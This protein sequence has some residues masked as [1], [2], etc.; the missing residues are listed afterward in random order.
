MLSM[1]V[2]ACFISSCTVTDSSKKQTAT[3]TINDMSKIYDGVAVEAK[4]STN[5]D[6]DITILYKENGNDNY[7]TVAPVNAGNYEIKITITETENYYSI[8]DEAAFTISKADPVVNVDYTIPTGLAILSGQKLSSIDLSAYNLSWTNEEIVVTEAG[9]YY[10]TFTPID[11]TNYN[12][13]TNIEINLSIVN[14]LV[15]IP[16]LSTSFD[17]DGTEKTISI[18]N[19]SNFNSEKMMIVEGDSSLSAT[20]AGTYSIV[21][22]LLDTTNY[23][24]SDGTTSN[25]IISWTISP[26]KVSEPIVTNTNFTYDGTEKAVTINYDSN[27][28]TQTGTTSA[29][30]ANTYTITFS[31]KDQT[32]NYVWE[33]DNS[34][35]NLSYTWKINKKQIENVTAANTSFVYN[36]EEQ[37]LNISNYN[38]EYMTQTGSISATNVG[39]YTVTYSLNNTNE[40]T[41]YAWTDGTIDDITISWEITPMT[42]SIPTITN[43]ALTYTGEELSPTLSYDSNYVGISS[44]STTKALQKGTYLITFVL[45]DK[46][47]IT[48]SDGTTNDISYTWTISNETI[49]IPTLSASF[50][51]DGTEKTISTANISNFNSEKMMIVEESSTLSATNA[52]TYNIIIAL[53]DTTNYAWNDGTTS[54][55]ALTWFINEVET[56]YD[57]SVTYTKG[58]DNCY[59]I[60]ENNTTGEYTITFGTI[61]AD[62]SYTLS[63]NLNGNIVIDVDETETYKFTLVLSDV[64]ITSAY[65][66][67]IFINT[68]SKVVINASEGTTNTIIDNREAIGSDSTQKSAAIYSAVDLNLSGSGTLNITS[69]NNNGVN[70]KD[71]LQVKN[72]TLNVTCVD[73]A[74]KGN[75]EV[76]IESG[77]ITLIATDGDGIKTSNN[78][79]SSK[80]NQKGN[81][82]ISGGNIT[83]YSGSDGID[84]AYDVIIS[85]DST[86]V[87][88]YTTS[89]YAGD[90]VSSIGSVVS[91]TYYILVNSS[92]TYTYSIRY[93]TTSGY[94]M[95]NADTTASKTSSGYN[96][97]PVDTVAGATSFEVYVYTSDQ[98]QG[99]ISDYY[100]VSSSKALNANYDTLQITSISSSSISTSWTLYETSSSSNSDKLVYSTKGLKANNEI[101][102]S[103]GTI[104][105]YAYDDAIHANNDEIIEST[106]TTGSGSVNLTGGTIYVKTHD[107][108]IHADGTLTID[109]ATVI[110]EE[111]YEGLEGNIINVV[112]GTATVT[113]SDDGVNGQSEINVS[114]GRLDVTVNP[115]GD[116]DGIDSNGTITISGGIVI[117]RGPNN[118]NACPLDA[119][120]TITITGGTTII[121]GYTSSSSSSG[122]SSNRPGGGPGGN[123]FGGG[124]SEGSLDVS[125]ELTTTQSN[126]SGL[127]SG[128]HTIT[129][130]SETIT[131][132]NAYTYSGYTT[133]YSTESATI[134]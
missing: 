26:I 69:V 91:G 74:L 122:S 97:Y 99:S 115:N 52:G 3:L 116:T 90:K 18:T 24:W 110:V 71:D 27:Y 40:V 5:S 55:K 95:V 93:K 34:Y 43:S 108:G 101:T 64:T 89:E 41:N 107:D 81:V 56:T 73:N 58:T 31:L 118:Q 113:A 14:N 15:D 121:I 33:S 83:I 106:S 38:S 25:K 65:N 54:N 32:G 9:T 114:G 17:Y 82:I 37:L 48:W 85:G 42:I 28:V 109:G 117:T 39:N 92:Y 11:S 130:G 20:N 100:V 86:V 61:A 128:E 13:I 35:V 6:G 59:T 45:N 66:S 124:A 23:A 77:T 133:V 98:T 94:T 104:T 63:G 49:N 70:T 120:G 29:T 79:L 84:A 19:I 102:I 62:T 2:C 112:S 46:T 76:S 22:S 47:N 68:A 21:V 16:T 8:S 12:I 134:S 75:D 129:I 123:P 126:S 50:D 132:T 111:S 57:F 127:S 67:P 36:G 7:S 10:A 119:D 87:N 60:S 30:D 53:L 80:L 131:Y 51:Y 72:Q 1:I 78:G 125:S 96:Y 105:I 4:Y 88:I 44:E 103:G